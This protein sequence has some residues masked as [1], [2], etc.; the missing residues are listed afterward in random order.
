MG[1]SPC[2]A[3]LYWTGRGQHLGDT[4][5]PSA[6][7]AI[8][9]PVGL[10]NQNGRMA[11]AASRVPTQSETPPSLMYISSVCMRAEV[12]TQRR[13]SSM[14]CTN[15]FPHRLMFNKSQSRVEHQA[16]WELL[17]HIMLFGPHTYKRYVRQR[18]QRFGLPRDS[19]RESSLS[20]FVIP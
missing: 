16:V 17:V 7:P 12:P 5:P 19:R 11:F 1:L 4:I 18:R 8:R 6:V 20:R 10:S 3:R 13:K 14:M 9:H 15:K 2:P